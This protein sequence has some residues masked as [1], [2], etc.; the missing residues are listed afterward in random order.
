MFSIPG[1]G[2]PKICR[3]LDI[4]NYISFFGTKW[5]P[6]TVVAHKVVVSLVIEKGVDLDNKLLQERPG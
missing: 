6:I 4:N 1:R 3:I 2:P 5:L